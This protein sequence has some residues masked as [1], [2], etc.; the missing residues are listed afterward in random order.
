[1]KMK[2]YIKIDDLKKLDYLIKS[3]KGSLSIAEGVPEEYKIEAWTDF[4]MQSSYKGLINAELMVDV[5]FFIWAQDIN[6][7]SKLN[8]V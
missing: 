4:D 2:L 8:Y 6:A 5:D 3:W 1:M 7:F